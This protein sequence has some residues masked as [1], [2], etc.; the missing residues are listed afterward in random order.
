MKWP[1]T[2]GLQICWTVDEKTLGDL[3]TAVIKVLSGTV[4]RQAIRSG[5]PVHPVSATSWSNKGCWAVMSCTD[6]GEPDCYGIKNL[7][8]L[9]LAKEAFVPW[10]LRGR[11]PR[12]FHHL[13][14]GVNQR[15]WHLHS[16]PNYN[17]RTML[18]TALDS[19]TGRTCVHCNSFGVTAE[20]SNVILD[21][22][23]CETLYG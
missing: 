19:R 3:S 20:G 6:L 10:T 9:D 22:L 2:L 13:W 16:R 4:R 18:K 8:F 17:E 23:Q 12:D 15:T 21:P 5:D 11:D 14:Q 1:S 7:H